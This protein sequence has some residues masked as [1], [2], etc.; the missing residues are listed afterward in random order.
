MEFPEETIALERLLGGGDSKAAVLEQFL[1]TVVVVPIVGSSDNGT[2]P[3][4]S[5]T[6]FGTL[7]LA[8][9]TGDEALQVADKTTIMATMTGVALVATLPAG[10]GIA[11]MGSEGNAAFDERLLLQ[12][13]EDLL[14]RARSNQQQRE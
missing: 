10:I 14:A 9:T 6:E 5:A 1:R 13:R 12:V 11:L 7:A 4:L 3:L 2:S 8:F